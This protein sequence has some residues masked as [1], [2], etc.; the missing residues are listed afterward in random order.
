MIASRIERDRRE[1]CRRMGLE[2]RKRVSECV[3][4]IADQR[5]AVRRANDRARLADNARIA[6]WMMRFD[7]ARAN[8]G[9]S[10][11]R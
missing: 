7:H 9:S 1:L 3:R 2:R 6:N 10:H 8:R 11:A 5:N 4:A